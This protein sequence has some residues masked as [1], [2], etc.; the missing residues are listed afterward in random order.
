MR[1]YRELFARIA[2]WLD[3]HGRLFVHVFAHKQ[4]AYRFANEVSMTGW[5]DISSPAA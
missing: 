2:R 3:E 1:N 4:L 5:H